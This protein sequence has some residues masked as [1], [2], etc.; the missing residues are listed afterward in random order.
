MLS[1]AGINSKENFAPQ[2]KL[3]GITIQVLF[4]L[5]TLEQQI[6]FMALSNPSSVNK[7]FF[8]QWLPYISIKMVF[9]H[10][11]DENRLLLE[12]VIAW[13]SLLTSGPWACSLR[14]IAWLLSFTA[15]CLQWSTECYQFARILIDKVVCSCIN[16]QQD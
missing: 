11:W 2:K 14:K 8:N 9:T 1:T 13:Q 10:S 6:L 16:H 7:S 4:W 12:S 3:W 15:S 5:L